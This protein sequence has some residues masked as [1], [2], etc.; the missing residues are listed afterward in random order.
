MTKLLALGF[1]AVLAFGCAAETGDEPAAQEARATTCVNNITA[2]HWCECF[3][4][5]DGSSRCVALTRP[6]QLCEAWWADVAAVTASHALASDGSC[7]PDRVERALLP[8][9]CLTDWHESCHP[10]WHGCTG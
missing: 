10:V 3:S 9:V 1:A 6:E 5:V 2:V 7:V 8:Q 4:M